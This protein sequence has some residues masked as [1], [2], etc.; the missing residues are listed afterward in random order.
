M[1]IVG[2]LCLVVFLATWFV[3]E[4]PLLA[5]FVAIVLW[6]ILWTVVKAGGHLLTSR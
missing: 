6:G 5:V 4:S 3:L 1:K 2:Y